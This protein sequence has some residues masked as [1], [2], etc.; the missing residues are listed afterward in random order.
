[1]KII[2]KDKIKKH[3][4]T[5]FPPFPKMAPFSS[6]SYFGFRNN[7]INLFKRVK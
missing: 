1:M 7:E 6:K 4:R 2:I 5:P 3:F